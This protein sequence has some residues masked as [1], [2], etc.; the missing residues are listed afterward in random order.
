VNKENLG[1]F[2]Y[3]SFGV[4]GVFMSENVWR[5]GLEGNCVNMG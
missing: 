4:G 2:V 1:S 3:F 5:F